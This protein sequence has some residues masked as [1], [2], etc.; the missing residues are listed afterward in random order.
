MMLVT[1]QARTRDT[2]VAM[3]ALA[4]SAI[5]PRADT[6]ANVRRLE[7]VSVTTG[8]SMPSVVLSSL[9][10]CEPGRAGCL[11]PMTTSASK[12]LVAM[13]A[14]RTV[15]SERDT[16]YQK[17]AGPTRHPRCTRSRPDAFLNPGVAAWKYLDHVD[18]REILEGKVWPRDVHSFGGGPM[19]ILDEQME[20]ASDADRLDAVRQLI[21][22]FADDDL[23]IRTY[24][25]L[26]SRHVARILGPAS[27][28]EAADSHVASLGVKGSPVWQ[29]RRE[30][31]ASEIDELLETETWR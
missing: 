23:L 6:R 16:R 1:I 13:M 26:S 14:T 27:L 8:S 24:A 15:R 11:Q 10:R 7:S 28:R 17:V 25:V 2:T 3:T 29:H 12:A 9:P 20:D 31:L 22:L 30:T 4:T 21:A 5:P 19:E 18:V